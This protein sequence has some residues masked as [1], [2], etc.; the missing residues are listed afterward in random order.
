MGFE[1][2]GGSNEPRNAGSGLPEAEEDM[3][4]ILPTASRRN[5]ALPTHFLL[6][7]SRTVRE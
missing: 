5:V 1:D 3:K 2:E 7:T 4:W 6:L